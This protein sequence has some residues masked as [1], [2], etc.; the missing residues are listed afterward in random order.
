MPMIIRSS[1][2]HK[3]QAPEYFE[4]KAKIWPIIVSYVEKEG[5]CMM[6]TC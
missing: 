2:S 6:Q 5:L 3:D 1:V 4:V